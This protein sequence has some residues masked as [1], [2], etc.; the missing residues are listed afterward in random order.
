[1]TKDPR[2]N[3]DMKFY[4]EHTFPFAIDDLWP[5]YGEPNYLAAK[6]KALGSS[7]LNIHESYTDAENIRVILERTITPDLH[8]IPDWVRKKLSRDYVMRHENRCQRISPER[9][10]F[11]L[12][13]IPAGAPVSILGKGSMLQNNKETFFKAEFDV[14][15]SIPLVGKKVA[16]VFA[17]KVREALSEDWAF[18]CNYVKNAQ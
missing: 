12:R 2:W 13:I 6:Y 4:V 10:D 5:V 8:S 11:Q 17:G 9:A 1:M 7:G 15:C 14:E 3:D 18:T 16:E